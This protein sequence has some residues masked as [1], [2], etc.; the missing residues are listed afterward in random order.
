MFQAFENDI[1]HFFANLDEVEIVFCE[2]KE[3]LSKFFKFKIG[4][5]SI[6]ENGFKATYVKVKNKVLGVGKWRFSFFWKLW[7]TR[8]KPFPGKR[9]N[10][11]ETF[12]VKFPLLGAF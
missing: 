5:R 1:F 6:L 12:Y 2:S 9:D 3:K 10:A 8:L 11:F 4:H 7:V